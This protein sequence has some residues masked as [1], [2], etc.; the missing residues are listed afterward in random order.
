MMGPF[1]LIKKYLLILF[2]VL[3]A[4]F[5]VGLFILGKKSAKKI[6]KVGIIKNR[7]NS[8]PLRPNCISSFSESSDKVHYLAPV[9]LSLNPI[10]EIKKISQ[11]LGLSLVESTDIYLYLT[12]KSS[13]FGFVDDIEFL[14][15]DRSKQLH[16]RSASRVGHSDMKK[17]RERVERIMRLLNN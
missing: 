11:R 12:A 1:V 7:L 9:K 8:C 3:G 6:P 16:F 10:T 5:A 15:D 14:Y 4:L 17:N 13:M 2:L